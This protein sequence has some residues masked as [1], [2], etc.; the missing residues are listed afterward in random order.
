MSSM[1]HILIAGGSSGI[2]LEIV[3]KVIA[4]GNRATVLSREIRDLQG[5]NAVSHHVVDFSLENP[6]LPVV[7]GPLE[8]IVYC[9]GTIN[10]KPFSSLKDQDFEDDFAVN[11]L[12]AVKTIRQYLPNFKKGEN[13]SIVLFSTVAVQT[14]MAYHAS[15]A[16]SKGAVE[17][18]TRS[19]AAEFAPDIRVN[20]IAPSLT[21][22]PLASRLLRNEKMVEQ[23]E[24]RNPLR[25]V[26]TPAD[27]ADMAIYL[28][29]PAARWISGQILA[30]DGGMG[31]LK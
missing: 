26:G 19:L 30:V 11:F 10:L 14:G 7:D 8:A 23:A 31:A 27:I 1:K 22:T 29:S 2:G 25:I 13:P 17:G 5:L 4:E 18:L 12:G 24:Q 16:A 6:A 28:I 3:K 15:V 9:P 20:C 21:D